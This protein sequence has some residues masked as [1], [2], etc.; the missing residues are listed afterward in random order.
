[1]QGQTPQDTSQIEYTK[2]SATNSVVPPPP[3]QKTHMLCY[4]LKRMEVR[5]GQGKQTSNVV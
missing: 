4:D 3:P 5:V 1:M 2:T